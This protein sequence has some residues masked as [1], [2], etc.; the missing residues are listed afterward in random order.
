MR[1]L[2]SAVSLSGLLLFAE[3]ASADARVEAAAQG[4]LKRAATDYRGRH[5]VAAAARLDKA[6]QACGS[7]RCLSDTRAAL[8][9]DLGT[10]QFRHGDTDAAAKSFADALALD[11]ELALNPHYETPDLQAAWDDAKKTASRADAKDHHDAA[12]ERTDAD[13]THAATPVDAPAAEPTPPDVSA[14]TDVATPKDGSRYAHFWIGVAGAVDLLVLPSGNDLCKL[15]P[16]AD[17]AN[18]IVTYCTNPDGSDF[19][20]HATYAQNAALVPGRSG[21]IRG[22]LQIGDLRAMVAFDYAL[23]PSLLVGAR[24]G[25]VLNTYPGQAAVH[26]GRAFSQR[27]HA[28]L[29]ATYLFGHEP[30]AAI[31][32]APMIFAGGGRSEFDGSLTSNVAFNNSVGADRVNIWITDGPWFL[33]LGGG[34]RYQFS[35]RA[36]FTAAVRVNTAFPGNGWLPTFG[37]ELGFQYG[38]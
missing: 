16:G 21:N 36:A 9:R 29:R 38:L 8:L 11:S 6:A 17:P 22:G 28:E 30:L 34:F 18:D 37:P 7:D 19:P 5:Y 23:S 1:L 32:F 10:M 15:T 27:Y 13:S 2:S 35:L 31:G 26:D 20:T 3:T 33:T 24:V 14:A 12:A 4:A 25:Y